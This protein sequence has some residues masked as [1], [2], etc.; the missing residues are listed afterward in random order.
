MFTQ[1]ANDFIESNKDNPFFL[2]FSFHDIHVPRL[3]HERFQGKSTMGPR[4]DAIIQMDWM[5]G[6]IMN[7]LRELGL[8][9]NTLVIFTSDNGPVLNDGYEDQAVEMLGEHNPAGP[10]RG[11]KYSA[12]EAGT[13]VPTIAYWPSQ[14]KSGESKALLSQIDIFA[15]LAEMVNIDI[16][17]DQAM[18]SE[19]I[20]GALLGKTEQGRSVMLEEAFTLAIR[21]GKWKYIHP[22]DSER[23]FPGW[24][25]DKKV[26][27][28]LD[29][30]PQLFNLDQDA[31]ESINVANDHPEIVAELQKELDAILAKGKNGA[32][33]VAGH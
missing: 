32:T 1:K 14:I 11:G 2:F 9:E 30:A 23:K 21:K 33:E 19:G 7:K 28:G 3:P 15:S 12:F 5:T 29:Y 10:Y 13:R 25:K 16:Q 8:E 20:A 26:E 24:L 27:A 6:E 4:G 18:D 22:F 17:P 31:S